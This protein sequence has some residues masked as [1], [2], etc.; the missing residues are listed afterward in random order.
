[1]PITNLTAEVLEVRKSTSGNTM[2]AVIGVKGQFQV[3]EGP[4]AINAQINF[5]FVPSEATV[6]TR[7][8]PGAAS[9]K[10]D[11]S[12]KGAVQ[13]R[14]VEGIYD[15]KGFISRVRLAHVLTA[16]LP[17]SEGRL[18]QTLTHELVLERRLPAP[19][20]TPALDVP[21]P[22]PDLTVANSWLIFDDPQG[23]FH[24]L[25]PQELRLAKLHPEGGVDLLDRRPDGQDVIMLSL[26]PKS[27][28]PQ[29]DRQ[30]A[31]PLVEKKKL[32][33]QWKRQ[34]EKVLA[35]SLGV[36]ARDRLGRIE[37]QGLSDRSGVDSRQC[38]CPAA[39]RRTNLP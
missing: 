18:K 3:E 25:H 28:D 23:R 7:G 8:T 31:D 34:G 5:T 30:A 26:V 24:L 37:A 10:D 32:E 16:P 13:P 12:A 4:T 27:D 39:G 38:R 15:A 21:N 36:A 1:M 19:D 29:A 17:G 6:P 11:A 14:R 20:S 22:P 35:R 33:D 9:A 2:T